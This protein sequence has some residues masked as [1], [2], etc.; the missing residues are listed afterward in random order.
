MGCK[1]N[2]ETATDDWPLMFGDPMMKLNVKNVL[3]FL[4]VNSHVDKSGF[5]HKKGEVSVIQSL[6]INY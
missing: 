4:N 1:L 6:L 2:V 3:N 5:L